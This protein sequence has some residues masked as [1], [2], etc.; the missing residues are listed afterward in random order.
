[1][2]V[3]DRATFGDTSVGEPLAGESTNSPSTLAQKTRSATA[4]DEQM[5]LLAATRSV[6]K[7]GA[8]AL[9]SE[10]LCRRSSSRLTGRIEPDSDNRQRQREEKERSQPHDG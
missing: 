5:T 4:G 2:A 7:S 10:C 9:T 6:R 3:I 8:T 1:M